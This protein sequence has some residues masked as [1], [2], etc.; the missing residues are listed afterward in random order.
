MIDFIAS[1]NQSYKDVNLIFHGLLDCPDQQNSIKKTIWFYRFHQS[2][3]R[4]SNLRGRI[5][6]SRWKKK[7]GTNL[8]EKKPEY[9]HCK[10]V[11]WRTLW[12]MSRSAL[13][14]ITFS[15]RALLTDRSPASSSITIRSDPYSIQH[16]HS[17]VVIDVVYLYTGIPLLSKRRKL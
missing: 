12:M 9:A 1:E 14:W 4:P 6:K 17:A 15:F 7:F 10:I 13:A 2:K 16:S 11:F 8:E 3:K 5:V